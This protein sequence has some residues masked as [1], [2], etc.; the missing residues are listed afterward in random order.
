MFERA[1]GYTHDSVKVFLPAGASKPVYAPYLKHVP[2]D[3]RA[4]EFWLTNRAPDR[5]KHKQNI[6][7]N[8][9]TD[10]PLRLLAEQISGHAIRPRLPEPKVIDRT[11]IELSAI[12]PQQP[13]APMPSVT[14]SSDIALDERMVTRAG[15]VT[16]AVDDDRL[17][18]RARRKD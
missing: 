18:E 11:D 13:T 9:A 7:H 3:P 5:W 4:G 10:S 2:P 6:E 12:R 14:T 17:R 8:E 16:P 15:V 1:V